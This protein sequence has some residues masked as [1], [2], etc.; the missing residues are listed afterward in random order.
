MA[1]IIYLTDA[2]RRRGII[3]GGFDRTYHYSVV[4]SN[5]IDRRRRFLVG[6]IYRSGSSM[7]GWG[8]KDDV[9]IIYTKLYTKRV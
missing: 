5:Y 3:R 8:R 6:G 7:V 4:L 1:I 9:L 2:I